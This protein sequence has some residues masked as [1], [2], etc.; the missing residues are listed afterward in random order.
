MTSPAAQPTAVEIENPTVVLPETI[1]MR[2]ANGEFHVN[3]GSEAHMRLVANGATIIDD[4][5]A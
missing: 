1:W 5:T 2:G 3:V 4:P